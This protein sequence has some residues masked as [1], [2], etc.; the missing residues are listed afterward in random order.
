MVERE[1]RALAREG[2]RSRTGRDELIAYL[3]AL[4]LDNPRWPT[5]EPGFQAMAQ[6]KRR[7]RDLERAKVLEAL[8]RP[9]Q[10]DEA[11]R[12]RT[13]PDMQPPRG[14]RPKR[15]DGDV[16]RDEGTIAGHLADHP[17]AT[18]DQVA[19]AT[20]IAKAHVSESIAWKERKKLRTHARNA[21]RARG[22]GGSART[23]EG[24]ADSDDE[25]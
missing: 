6:S 4:D 10:P 23:L 15:T 20:G 2:V 25:D 11:V 22:A 16:A 12:S 8:S 17:E 21:N 19:E 24:T 1:I 7:E 3:Q 18:R 14:R 13:E 5:E 9:A